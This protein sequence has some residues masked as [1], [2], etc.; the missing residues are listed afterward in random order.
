MANEVIPETL[1]R[2]YIDSFPVKAA[3]IDAASEALVG[4]GEGQLRTLRDLAHKLAGSAG[5]YGFDDLGQLARELV[6][7]IDAGAGTSVLVGLSRDLTGRLAG[8]RAALE[9]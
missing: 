1:R 9:I 6:H 5:M 2:R 7:A 4:D 3:A 8:A